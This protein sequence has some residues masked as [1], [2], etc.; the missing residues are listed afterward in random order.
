MTGIRAAL[1]AAVAA[2]PVPHAAIVA[3]AAL[4]GLIAVAL[5]S[6]VPVALANASWPSR[7]PGLALLVWQAIGLWGG[8]TMIAALALAGYSLARSWLAVLPAV[9]LAAYLL[10]HL[11]DTLADS[12]RQ[13][14]RH[15]MLLDL[16]AAPDPTRAATFVL[17]NPA[18]VA[19]CLP[20]GVGS[21]T[22]LSRGLLD[23]LDAGA[24]RA[25]IAHER[26]H[27]EQRH[28]LLLLA[29]RAWRSALPWFPVAAYAEVE[30]AAL[31][32]MLADDVARR[33]VRDRDL[34][35]AILT[36]GAS[37]T[38]PADSAGS[39]TRRSDRFRRLAA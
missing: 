21:V 24:L 3:A 15:L 12:I 20:R 33:D 7:R 22:V 26:A 11:A 29:F 36:V 39:A 37:G 28:D 8:L 13:R 16:L 25:V 27:V 31:V 30:V 18:P 6:R 23:S 1:G 14:R 2:P 10:A 4:L 38:S 19:Y 34:V 5:A 35:R 9:A 17:D 32:E